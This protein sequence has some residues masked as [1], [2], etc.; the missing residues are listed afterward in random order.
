[1]KCSPW[2]MQ[3][4]ACQSAQQLVELREAGICLSGLFPDSEAAY[5]KGHTSHYKSVNLQEKNGNFEP[6]NKAQIV[7]GPVF[8]IR[9]AICTSSQ[10][11]YLPLN[12]HSFPK[13]EGNQ[14]YQLLSITQKPCPTYCS[15]N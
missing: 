7:C 6:K 5:S 4:I 2:K 10:L 11:L 13:S 12:R 3:N 15:V 1:M 14:C 9:Q 8:A